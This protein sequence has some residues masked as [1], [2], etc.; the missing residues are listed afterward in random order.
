M[1]DV[2]SNTTHGAFDP[3]SPYSYITRA[4]ASAVFSVENLDGAMNISGSAT[5]GQLLQ[6]FNSDLVYWSVI[7]WEEV[8][9]S[10]KPFVWQD[11]IELNL[12]NHKHASNQ[13]VVE[14]K[15]ASVPFG[16]NVL[17]YFALN[18]SY[19]NLNHGSYGATS[20]SGTKGSRSYEMAMEQRPD[21]WFRYVIYDKMDELRKVFCKV[22][23]CRPRR[24]RL[25][26]KCIAWCQCYI[27]QSENQIGRKNTF[28]ECCLHNGQEYY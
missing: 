13:H 20:L 26:A 6:D 5:S 19:V 21:E 28:F 8:D 22:Y 2:G 1:N 12:R 11:E 10:I 3:H 27:T 16:H 4:Q 14:A 9:L 23:Q 7:E 18:K 15:Q 25:R 17:Q 24:D